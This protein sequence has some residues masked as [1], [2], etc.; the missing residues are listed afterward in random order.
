MAQTLSSN[1]SEKSLLLPKNHVRLHRH[2]GE[3]Q[4]NQEDI[5]HETAFQGPSPTLL[6]N[7][8]RTNSSQRSRQYVR[9]CGNFCRAA[10]RRL[11]K[12]KGVLFVFLI[13]FL[14]TFAFYSILSGLQQI[15]FGK[16]SIDAI[17]VFTLLEGTAGRVVYPVA[18][19][20]ADTYLGRYQVIHIGLW[21]LWIGFA[22]LA[23]C[24]SLVNLFSTSIVIGFILPIISAV[25]ISIG[26]GSVEVN[27]VSFG[28]DQLAQ[29]A[30]SEELSSYFFWYY[31]MRN[32]GYFAA[33]LSSFMLQASFGVDVSDKVSPEDYNLSSTQ[34]V[35]AV[36]SV[37]L[38]LLLHYCLQKWYFKDRSRENPLRSILN[39]LYFSATVKRGPPVYRR[40]FRRGEEKKPRIELAKKDYDGIFPSA[41]VED[42]KTFCRI[43]FLLITLAGYFLTF[44]AVSVLSYGRLIMNAI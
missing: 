43:L 2:G 17:W 44:T 1:L 24:Q 11:P 37:T 3:T 14:E 42:V 12:G 40:A 41:E 16:D 32:A 35:L 18:G 6:K 29:G 25:V 19:V 33:I 36:A 10:R 28:V 27:A 9:N 22:I 5:I 31:V 7:E 13:Y 30:P 8:R 15:L 20:I 39:V 23:L 26:A 38:A 34:S 4:T 21:L